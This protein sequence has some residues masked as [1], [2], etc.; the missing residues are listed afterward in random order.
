MPVE[1]KK[2]TINLAA[3][4][5]PD[6]SN[7]SIEQSSDRVTISLTSSGAKAT[8]LLHGATI[9][10][11]TA[12]GREQLWLSTASALDGSKAVRGGIP[13]VFPVF[14]PPPPETPVASLPQHGF[15]RTSK[16]SLLGRSEDDAGISVDLGLGS[17][18]LSEDVRSKW[19]YNFNLIYSVK[20]TD[21]TLETKMVVQNAEAERSFDFNVLFHTYLRIPN[22]DNISVHNLKDLTYRDKTLGNSTHSEKEDTIKITGQTDRVYMDAPDEVVVQDDGKPIFTVT[23]TGL[24][25]VVVWNPY[26]STEKI[27]DWEPKEGYK[28]MVCIEAGSVA[29]F[30]T[31]EAGAAWEGGV[32]HKAHL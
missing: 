23:K 3:A 20:L 5:A 30:Q 21:D 26:D 31:L 12:H 10:S 17:E 7:A 32:V 2:P 19:G 14:G 4:A 8:I 28:N 18:S 1:K 16:W 22:V 27:G 11:W 29:A 25:D 15:A 13:L 9:I 6:T 24:K